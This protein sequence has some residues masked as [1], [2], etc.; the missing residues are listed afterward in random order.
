[1]TPESLQAV[2]GAFLQVYREFPAMIRMASYA[3]AANFSASLRAFFVFLSSL[4]YN[5]CVI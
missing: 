1:M 2:P 3:S 5:D 4:P